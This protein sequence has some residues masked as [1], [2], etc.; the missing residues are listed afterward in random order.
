MLPA[1]LP[2]VSVL[3]GVARQP[4]EAAPNDTNNTMLAQMTHCL[5]LN[6]QWPE[7]RRLPR[8]LS[9]FS[10]APAVAAAAARCLSRQCSQARCLSSQCILPAAGHG[11]VRVWKGAPAAPV[12]SW[13]APAPPVAAGKQT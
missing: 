12:P 5:L 13:H 6:K 1:P 4:L 3:T 10:T 7:S 9:S 8:L 11:R 2:A